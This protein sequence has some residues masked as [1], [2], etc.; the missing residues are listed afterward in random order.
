MPNSED[1]DPQKTDGLAVEYDS[2]LA[3]VFAAMAE[4]VVVQDQTG[5]ILAC[6]SSAERILGL[7]ADQITGRT[8]L[9]PRWRAV[10][11]DGSAFPGD[12]HPAMVTLRTGEAC[13]EIVMGVHRPDGTLAWILIN[14]RLLGGQDERRPR[15]AVTTFAEITQLRLLQE[16][17]EVLAAELHR[18]L[19]KALSGY[20]PICANCKCIRDAESN[21]IVLEQY[22]KSRTGAD[23]TH[24]VCP[25]CAADLYPDL[26]LGDE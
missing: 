18:T 12:S 6:N 17:R 8:S 21:W 25:T 19:T 7:T 5:A 10:H 11:E 3:A 23:F 16:E 14:S 4:G 24:T 22:I 15:A 1:R 9:D 20:L 13:S 26:T 2:I